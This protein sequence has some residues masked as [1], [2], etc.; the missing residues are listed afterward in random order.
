MGH[1]LS[2]RSHSGLRRLAGVAFRDHPE[3]SLPVRTFGC[4]LLVGV[5]VLA[6]IGQCLGSR[7]PP[8]DQLVQQAQ[9]DSLKQLSYHVCNQAAPG[10][11]FRVT[12]AVE[13]A[14]GRWQLIRRRQKDQVVC[15]M[16]QG[17][18]WNVDTAIRQPGN[19]IITK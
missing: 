15:T 9:E 5:L 4:L 10:L 19:G 16:W 12:E 6:G 18:L 13:R 7:Q 2:I 11:R 1:H 8:V 14:P 3:S 17:S